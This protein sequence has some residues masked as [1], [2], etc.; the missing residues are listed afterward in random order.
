MRNKILTILGTLVILISIVS[1]FLFDANIRQNSLSMGFNVLIA[2]ENIQ[3]GTIIKSVDEAA[4]L[5]TTR[6]IAQTE[7]VENAIKVNSISANKNLI[8]R[9]KSKLIPTNDYIKPEDLQALVN[10]KVVNQIYKNQQVLSLDLSEDTTTF[11]SDERYFAIPVDYVSSVGAEISKGDYVDIW[12]RYGN[13]HINAGQSEKVIG[14]LKIQNIKDGN[15]EAIDSEG[16]NIPGVVIL[17]VNEKQIKLLSELMNEGTLFL[18]KWGITPSDNT[19]F[20]A[21]P[22]TNEVVI[23]VEKVLIEENIQTQTETTVPSQ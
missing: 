9:I 10:K 23:E 14:P 8:E 13:K 11:K 1:V 4:S 21:E 20:E 22:K 7:A 2:K 18:T 3:E 16:S 6:R 17:K 15:N 5:F 12:I 19:Y